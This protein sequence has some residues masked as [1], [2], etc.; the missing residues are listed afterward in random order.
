M[1]NSNES[2][3]FFQS[4]IFS[5]FAFWLIRTIVVH[6]ITSILSRESIFRLSN[7]N[8]MT[9]KVV[10]SIICVSAGT[11]AYVIYKYALHEWYGIMAC[12]ISLGFILIN[13]L[14]KRL[15]NIWHIEKICYYIFLRMG[16]AN[17]NYI[18]KPY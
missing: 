11:G 16:S 2:V 1:L 4:L 15:K 6:A 7:W 12:F 17:F 13:P 10:I 18:L 8:E 14:M 3:A 5:F 9:L